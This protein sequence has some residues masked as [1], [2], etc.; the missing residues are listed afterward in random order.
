[1]I[2]DDEQ[3]SKPWFNAERKLVLQVALMILFGIMLFS[4]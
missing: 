4:G 3:Q 1:M 2:D